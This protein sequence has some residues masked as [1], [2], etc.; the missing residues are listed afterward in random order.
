ME[1]SSCHTLFA[2]LCKI[3][4]FP[5]SS[6]ATLPLCWPPILQFTSSWWHLPGTGLPSSHWAVSVTCWLHTSSRSGLSLLCF[7]SLEVICATCQHF[8]YSFLPECFCGGELGGAADL[9][10]GHSF[11]TLLLT[12]SPSFVYRSWGI[13][14]TP[15]W[16]FSLLTLEEG[17]F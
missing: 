6:L 11:L 15:L 16:L 10:V 17:R 4:C 3:A 7:Y 1:P 14:L 2:L 13:L 12:I 5:P 8:T 9:F